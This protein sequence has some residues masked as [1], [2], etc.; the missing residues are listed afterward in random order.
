[1]N[2]L[3]RGRLAAWFCG[4]CL[5]TAALIGSTPVPLPAQRIPPKLW[6]GGEFFLEDVLGEFRVSQMDAALRIKE[7]RARF[8]MGELDR[9]ETELSDAS[10]R[11][12]P[13]ELIRVAQADE[14]EA[15]LVRAFAAFLRKRDYEA[16][17]WAN[18]VHRYHPDPE[19]PDVRDREADL[20]KALVLVRAEVL[21]EAYF[22][23]IVDAPPTGPLP[24]AAAL[25]KELRA[26]GEFAGEP[27]VPRKAH[28]RAADAVVVVRG[29]TDAE[30]AD[31][32]LWNVTFFSE[33]E[34]FIGSIVVEAYR[35]QSDAAKRYRAA[36]HDFDAPPLVLRDYGTKAPNLFDVLELADTLTPRIPVRR[37]FGTTSTPLRAEVEALYWMRE[38]VAPL[39]AYWADAAGDNDQ[40]REIVSEPLTAEK[41][42]KWR[43]MDRIAVGGAGDDGALPRAVGFVNS[44][45]P[46]GAEFVASRDAWEHYHFVLAT[47]DGERYRGSYILTS[48]FVPLAD[49]PAGGTRLYFLR[50]QT[51]RSV[52]ELDVTL[53]GDPPTY[54]AVADVV[55]GRLEELRQK[56]AGGSK[57]SSPNGRE[58]PP[59]KEESSK[60]PS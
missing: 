9:V 16:Y 49:D 37:E 59:S 47:G 11:P 60:K 30:R 13:E 38:N 52:R 26:Q 2:W 1:M 35:P 17:F 22:W 53:S 3:S 31:G 12:R 6:N 18:E 56:A 28:P 45:V 27:L 4:A 58:E 51:P 14:R 34:M 29:A 55:R 23:S 54:D 46:T 40:V 5:V 48:K 32:Q 36:F 33:T 7:A 25:A 39:A 57:P 24:L 20:I 42:R 8:Q 44:D 10:Q 41:R 21:A 19:N 43:R 50:L 15:A